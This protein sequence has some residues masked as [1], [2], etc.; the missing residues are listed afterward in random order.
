M[1]PGGPFAWAAI[2]TWLNWQKRTPPTEAQTT[3]TEMLQSCP[4]SLIDR[5]SPDVQCTNTTTHCSSF[6]NHKTSWTLQAVMKPVTII[7]HT[8]YLRTRSHMQWCSVTG[9]RSAVWSLSILCVPSGNQLVLGFDSSPVTRSL[10][11]NKVWLEAFSLHRVRGFGWVTPSTAA[12]LTPLFS[13]LFFFSSPSSPFLFS[14]PA[15]W[16]SDFS[17]PPHCNTLVKPF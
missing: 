2:A 15:A 12:G 1:T 9:S 10:W 13:C 4:Y 5:W 6:P 11:A 7:I 17:G 8:L 14:S 3:S 16:R